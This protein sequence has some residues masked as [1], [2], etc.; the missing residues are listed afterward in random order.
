MLPRVNSSPTLIARLV[1]M[2]LPAIV[3]VSCSLMGLLSSDDTGTISLSIE[4]PMARTIA[5]NFDMN[6]AS[7]VVT[8]SGPGGKTFSVTSSKTSVTRNGLKTGS[9]SIAVNAMNA[10]NSLIARGT[11]VVSV[12]GNQTASLAVTIMPLPGNGS[13][14]VSLTWTSASIPSVSLVGELLPVSGA[15][16]PL[17]FSTGVG[18]ATAR[19]ASV[20]AGYYT[21]IIQLFSAGTLVTGAVDVARIVQGQTTP[22]AYD[23]TQAVATGGITD[24]SLQV[25]VSP[26]NT[27]PLEISLSGQATNLSAGS[28]ITVTA[29]A[30]GYEGTITC[31][32]Y[33]NG[34][35]IVSGSPTSSSVTVGGNLPVGSY[36]LDVAAF[37]ADGMR[38]GSS[39]CAFT[40]H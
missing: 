24:P 28:S 23:F 3:A 27:A 35:S 39:T 13:L 29:N 2:V 1:P 10:G 14:S 34:Q 15:A 8:G 38:A 37:S 32:W 6:P 30:A 19:A 4:T 7:F 21:L 9:W 16:I 18:T 22:G 26:E 11:G 20:P 40:I 33:L 31:V 25:S 17:T 5:P 12:T 36:R